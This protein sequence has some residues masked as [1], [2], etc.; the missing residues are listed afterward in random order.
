MSEILLIIFLIII[1]A[2]LN[3]QISFIY[4]A[5]AFTI[6]LI[7]LIFEKKR[8]IHIAK[9]FSKNNIISSYNI[10]LIFELVATLVALP[11]ENGKYLESGFQTFILSQLMTWIV[12]RCLYKKLDF[13]KFC[14]IYKII[15]FILSI[16]GAYETF[17]REYILYKAS[18]GIIQAFNLSYEHTQYFR[19]CM[20]FRVPS[21]AAVA[22]LTE[23]IILI[24]IP[25]KSTILQW[26]SII[27]A[28]ICLYG[29]KSRIVW[30]ATLIIF[31]YLLILILK[32]KNK[33]VS[34]QRRRGKRYKVVTALLLIVISA[35]ILVYF[36]SKYK[37]AKNLIDYLS[38]MLSSESNYGSREIRLGNINNALN[39][40]SRNPLRIFVGGG[41]GYGVKFSRFNAIHTT[42]GAMWNS[43]IDNEYVTI[44]LES[45][46]FGLFIYVSLLIKSLR[47]AN[48]KNTLKS[49]IGVLIIIT[50]IVTSF[51]FDIFW[52]KLDC[53]LLQLGIL[54]IQDDE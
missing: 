9:P 28:L 12:I 13:Q 10:F 33:N 47:L 2:D 14:N 35:I 4:L 1:I 29:T 3:T 25:F 21:I 54:A 45:G 6:I 23:L 53:L 24:Y 31:V 43:G 5:F 36:N 19:T 49:K 18:N 16:E 11:F 41:L 27:L 40:L 7:E 34:N 42:E 50:T 46:I 52:W 39:F 8:Y 26:I 30:I 32:G 22:I 20:V 37:I 38:L 44:L 51:G 15:I 48:K 17:A